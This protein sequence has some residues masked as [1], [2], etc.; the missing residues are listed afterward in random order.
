M[1]YIINSGGLEITNHCNLDCIHCYIDGKISHTTFMNYGT[2]IHLIE[3][4]I[5]HKAS[6]ITITGGEP[7]LHPDIERIITLIGTTY[8]ATTFYVATNGTAFSDKLIERIRMYNNIVLQ[9]SLDGSCKSTHEKQHGINTFNRVMEALSN[10]VDFP[11]ER[12]IVRMTISKVNYKECVSVAEIARQYNAQTSF[13]YVSKVGRACENW[14]VLEMSLSQKLYANELLIRYAKMYPDERI[15]PPVS[16]QSCSFNDPNSNLNVT[17]HVDGSADICSCLDTTYFIGN[18]Y[19]DSFDKMLNS[20]KIDEIFA[21][22]RKRTEQ[23]KSTACGDCPAIH[24]CRQGCIG[25]ASMNG[26]E[27]GHDGECP[28]RKALLF[29]NLFMHATKTEGWYK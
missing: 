21:K 18:A 7:L 13:V 10:L 12:K 6:F 5:L 23:I 20:P 1:R 22:T 28:Y 29:K 14:A 26:D 15:S 2:I 25:R 4:F 9:I 8:S 19:T 11:R 16:V 17:I 24:K 3:E 27:M